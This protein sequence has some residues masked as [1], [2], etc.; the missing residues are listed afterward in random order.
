MDISKLMVGQ[1][2]EMTQGIYSNK[3]KVVE[4]TSSSV[5]VS[6]GE[7]TSPKDTEFIGRKYHLVSFDKDGKETADSRYDRL[8]LRPKQSGPGPEFGPWELA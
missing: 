7:A 2:V 8:G 5:V 6:V 3:G 1:K 4:V